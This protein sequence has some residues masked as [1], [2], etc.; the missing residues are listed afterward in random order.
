MMRHLFFNPQTHAGILSK[1]THLSIEMDKSPLMCATVA[2]VL[3]Y[4]KDLK[5]LELEF[6]SQGI[7]GEPD[8]ELLEFIARHSTNEDTLVRSTTDMYSHDSW[9]MECFQGTFHKMI[10]HDWVA[11]YQHT[12]LLEEPFSFPPS[13][14][15]L[16]KLSIFR[17]KVGS[18]PCQWFGKLLHQLPHLLVL[19]LFN[20]ELFEDSRDEWV[21]RTVRYLELDGVNVE[22]MARELYHNDNEVFFRRTRFYQQWLFSD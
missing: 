19:E 8:R 1:V 2:A 10:G 3:P 16:C 18:I 22:T 5:E 20:L 14:R 11:K 12:A 15:H 4:V 7:E 21:P 17:P 9:P 13:F 6:C